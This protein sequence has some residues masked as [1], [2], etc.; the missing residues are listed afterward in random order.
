MSWPSRARRIRI[1]CPTGKRRSRTST[2]WRTGRSTKNRSSEA[3]AT[4]LKN[5]H[6]GFYQGL[7]AGDPGSLPG[8][9][10]ASFF[11]IPSINLTRTT[12]AIQGDAA[13]TIIAWI[14]TT[15][16]GGQAIVATG[17]PADAQA[18]NVV[19]YS[20]CGTVGVMGYNNDFYPCGGSSGIDSTDGAWHMV[21]VVYDGLGNLRIYADGILDN[22]TT[23]TYATSGQENYIGRSNHDQDANCAESCARPFRGSIDDV[24]VFDYALSDEGDRNARGP[25]LGGCRDG[26]PG[27][28][29][30]NQRRWSSKTSSLQSGI[31]STVIASEKGGSPR[32]PD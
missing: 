7:E 30:G 9:R 15:Y 12:V 6:D 17:F 13:R 5:H 11:G 28:R 22:T 20:G 19:M 21:A 25:E 24:A 2:L 26:Q 16:K 29:P 3:F 31:G 8:G 10:A 14:K 1:R 32:A 23:M 27:C 18:F 4:V